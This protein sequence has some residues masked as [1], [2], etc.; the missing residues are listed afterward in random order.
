[1]NIVFFSSNY[2]I[3]NS[4]SSHLLFFAYMP[5]VLTLVPLKRRRANRDEV[6][7][8]YSLEA[9]PAVRS[10]VLLMLAAPEL[11]INREVTELSAIPATCV[12]YRYYVTI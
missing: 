5:I 11:T 2:S 1:M 6:E 9:E 4:K 8:S 10:A 12:H 7:V 3:L